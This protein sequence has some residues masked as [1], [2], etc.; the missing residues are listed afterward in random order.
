MNYSVLLISRCKRTSNATLFLIMQLINIMIN[1][2]NV[3]NP[4]INS[5]ACFMR[6]HQ[7]NPELNSQPPPPCTVHKPTFSTVTLKLAIGT[8]YGVTALHCY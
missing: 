8:R 7:H 4:P 1:D 6:Y 5:C 2:S 3:F